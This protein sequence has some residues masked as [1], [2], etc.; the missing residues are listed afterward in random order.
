MKL[1]PALL[2]ADRVVLHMPSVADTVPAPDE[3]RAT[4]TMATATASPITSETTTR[5][6]LPI[7]PR[8][9]FMVSSRLH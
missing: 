3:A 2:A 5:S 4:K 9:L 6:E 7:M 8:W 1:S